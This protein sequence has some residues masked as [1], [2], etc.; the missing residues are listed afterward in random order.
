[1]ESERAS[2]RVFSPEE[3]REPKILVEIL[4]EEINVIASQSK[5]I[6]LQVLLVEEYLSRTETKEKGI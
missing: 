6:S 1:M 4:K 3:L 2:G 5:M